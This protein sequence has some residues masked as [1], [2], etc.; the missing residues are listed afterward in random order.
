VKRKQKTA[1]RLT[2][3]SYGDE[4]AERA[5]RQEIVTHTLEHAG[6]VG[7]YLTEAGFAVGRPYKMPGKMPGKP[8]PRGVHTFESCKDGSLV[9]YTSLPD[10]AVEP[11][12]VE[13]DRIRALLYACIGA[14]DRKLG[15]W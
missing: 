1:V 9:I 2:V 15:A 10:G 4:L 14:I 11:I 12:R 8:P 13:P 3:R 7:A 6:F 5:R